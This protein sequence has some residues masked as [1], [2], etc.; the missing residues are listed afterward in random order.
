MRRAFSIIEVILAAFVLLTGFIAIAAVF[1]TSYRE[2]SLNQ[3]RVQAVQLAR[4]VLDGIRAR[5]SRSIPQQLLVPAPQNFVDPPPPQNAVVKQT[6]VVEGI[7]TTT[8]FYETVTFASGR[9]S[10]VPT[11]PTDTATV[12]I[13]WFEAGGINV[14]NSG[15]KGAAA[16][17][18]RNQVQVLGGVGP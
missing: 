17:T 4:N 11:K 16:A 2:S 3:N 10:Q 1:P 14:G 8:E 18:K 9:T 6:V 5:Y 12:T 15:T 7:P 13:T